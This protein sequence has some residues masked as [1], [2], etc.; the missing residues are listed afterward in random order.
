[1]GYIVRVDGWRYTEWYQW[2]GR[3]SRPRWN[4]EGQVAVELYEMD[5]ERKEGGEEG[6]TPNVVD[7]DRFQDVRARLSRVLSSTLIRCGEKRRREK[8]WRWRERL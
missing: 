5:K 3:R 7:D 8:R 2:E 4:A 1:M 6:V